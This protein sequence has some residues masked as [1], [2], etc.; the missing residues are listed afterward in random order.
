[1]VAWYAPGG[2]NPL[3]PAM[4]VAIPL[5]SKHVLA[6]GDVVFTRGLGSLVR[7][8]ADGPPVPLTAEPGQRVRVNNVGPWDDKQGSLAGLDAVYQASGQWVLDV[9]PLHA[10]N[11]NPDFR[12]GTDAEPLTGYQ[13]DPSDGFTVARMSDDTGSFVRVTATQENAWVQVT[14]REPLATLDGAPVTL[15]GQIRAHATQPNAKVS[16]TL[17]DV[18]AEDGRV[19]QKISRSLASEEWT[20]LWAQ[21]PNVVYPS[22]EDYFA[23]GLVRVGEGDWF[24]IRELSLFVGLLPTPDDAFVIE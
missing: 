9:A 6:T 11:T 23:L 12:L 10:A 7:L 18:V 20:T 17:H 8:R 22:P 15:R 14:A 3:R 2:T 24:D 16:L 19:A 13:M 21:L 1:M 4:S 5:A